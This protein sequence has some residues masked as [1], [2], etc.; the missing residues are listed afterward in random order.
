VL[1]LAR[2]GVKDTSMNNSINLNTA[3]FVGIDAHPGS[4]T[5]CAINRFGDEKGSITVANSKHGMQE[6]LAWL[7]TIDPDANKVLIGVEGG[8]TSRT[9]LFLCLLKDYPSVYEVNPLWTKQ[10]RSMGTRADKSDVRDAKLIAEILT[11]KVLQLPKMTRER[12]ATERICLQKTVAFYED[13]TVQGAR[14]QNQLHQLRQEHSL[15]TDTLSRRVLT[16]LITEKVR[17]LRQIRKTQ[18]S[19]TKEFVQLLTGIG[20]NVLTMPG[21]GEVLTARLVAHTG[22]VSRFPNRDSFIRY[23]GI[24]PVEQSSGNKRGHRQNRKGNRKLNT[25]LYFV[26]LNQLRHNGQAR[27]YFEKKVSEGKSKK[28]A[29][30][31]LMKRTACILYGMLKSGEVYWT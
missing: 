14:L 30:R 16:S 13:I 2:S 6:L 18:Y 10:R 8:G 5:S 21:M 28:H 24:A 11:S 19:L 23:A 1:R 29:L 15:S 31:C 17:S 25:T 26:A 7:A 12:L 22:D 27:A 20:K 9:A 4:H 3:T